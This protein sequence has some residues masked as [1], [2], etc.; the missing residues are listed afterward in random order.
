MYSWVEHTSELE[1]SI[2]APSEAAVFTDALAA[3][4]E[5]VGDGRR[6]R[7]EER[8]LELAAGDLAAL[9]ADWLDELVYLADAQRFVP[10]GVAA[11]ELADASLRATVRGHRGE[12]G[13]LVKAVT[14]HRLAFE[15]AGAAGWRARVVLD[16]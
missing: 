16:V 2:D 10:E 5:L 3:F 15:P 8:E 13:A 14:R 7:A 1:L 6:G 9:L 4:V 11:F 12:P